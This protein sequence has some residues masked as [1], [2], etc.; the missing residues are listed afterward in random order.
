MKRFSRTILVVAAAVVVLSLSACTSKDNP[1]E[2]EGI[3]PPQAWA[4]KYP[5]IVASFEKNAEMTATTYG[6]SEPYSYLEKYEFLSSFYDGYG[7]SKQYDR[8]RGHVYTLED[9]LETDRPKK[10]A[11]CFACKSPDFVEQLNSQGVEFNSMK[12]EEASKYMTNSITCYDCHMEEP[13]TINLTLTHLTD[14]LENVDRKYKD[15]TLACAQCHV[16]YYQ[17]PETIA[18]T[19][20]WNNGL[21]ADSMI[22]YYDER[23]YSDWIHPQTGTPLLKAQHPEFETYQTG[24]HG[25][26]SCI[27]CHMEET[28]EYGE[29]VKAHQ[30]TSPLLT[31]MED[32]CIKCHTADTKESLTA[33][34]EAIQKPVYEKTLAVADNISRL[35]DE[36]SKA[37]KEGTKTEE[38]LDAVRKL[39]REA[40][41]KWD[42]VFVE[43][44]EGFHN[45][46]LA[47]KL[48]DEANQLALEGLELLK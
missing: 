9:V 3:V 25:N 44:G 12:F 13:G 23:G 33:K 1:A 37:V 47:H 5:S 40:Q 42:F 22:A 17:D 2:P 36:L 39:H 11:S 19:L 27:D 29:A 21:D 45:Q 15:T 32:T 26:L 14:K 35:I 16:E 8:A 46:E 41:F 18:I 7:F 48:L 28:E 34:V 4:D 20:P 43:N 24:T 31:S 10:G 30:W 38:E 6:G